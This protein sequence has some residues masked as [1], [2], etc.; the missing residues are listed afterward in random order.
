MIIL[1]LNPSLK[2]KSVDVERKVKMKVED[3]LKLPYTRIT[4]EMN[5]DTGHYFVGRILELNGCQSSGE[6]IEE[7]YKNLD[8]A[9]RG[10]IAVKLENN[11]PIAKPQEVFED[12]SGKFVVRV[13][14]TLHQEL[15]IQAQNEGVSLNQLILYK[16]AK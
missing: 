13:P 14:K 5:D 16:L 3:Y 11:L 7:L 12:Y 1:L 2:G 4:Q 6:T 15:A 8:E 9:L 10:Y